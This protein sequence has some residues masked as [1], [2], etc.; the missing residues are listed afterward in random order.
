M[1]KK[2]SK[3]TRSW[4]IYESLFKA[5]APEPDKFNE[6]TQ[7]FEPVPRR[8][9]DLTKGQ[10]INLAMTLNRIQI[11]D[12]EEMG[13]SRSQITK[14]AKAKPM[15]GHED[16]D[17]DDNIT[18]CWMLEVSVSYRHRAKPGRADDAMN[19]VLMLARQNLKDTSPM[20]RIAQLAQGKS[21]APSPDVIKP[22]ISDSLFE[23]M[24]GIGK[25]DTK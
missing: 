19:K 16:C 9:P 21:P 6:V 17:P 23:D 11:Q 25:K 5:E 4:E 1:A 24:F 14:S 8:F 13:L 7:R 3:N 12:H 10:A 22:P 15:P 18:K 20:A 2:I